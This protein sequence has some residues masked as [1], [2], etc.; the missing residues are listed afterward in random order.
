VSRGVENWRLNGQALDMGTFASRSKARAR[1]AEATIIRK[2]VVGHVSK[3]ASVHAHGVIEKSLRIEDVLRMFCWDQSD[4]QRVVVERESTIE[5]S[6]GVFKMVHVYCELE[7][8]W[9]RAGLEK[10]RQAFDTITSC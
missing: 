2:A 8:A 3:T 9:L 5:R 7:V 1:N 6:E 10:N 4:V